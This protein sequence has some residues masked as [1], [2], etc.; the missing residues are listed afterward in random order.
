[1]CAICNFKIEFGIGHP[2]GLSVAVATR[3]AIEAG[4]IVP[5]EASEGALS[6]AR[7][8]MSAIDALNLLQARIEG[9]HAD[10]ELMSLPDFYVLLIE[11]ETWGFFHATT[12]GFDP[13]IVPG[14]PD[15]TTTDEATRS[16]VIVTSEAGLRAWLDGR[17]KTEDALRD[18][19]FVVDAPDAQVTPLTD[20]LLCA[21]SAVIDDVR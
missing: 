6:A 17:I 9:A 20:M 15:L 16:S 14:M 1:M 2:S 11:N 8:R 12:T 3:K 19:I 5:I 4:Q 13:D 10:D 7:T 18:L 21:G